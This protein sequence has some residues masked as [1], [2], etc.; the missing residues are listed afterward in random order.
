[1]LDMRISGDCMIA[2]RLV[3]K[4]CS[5]HQAGGHWV[6]DTC[7]IHGGERRVHTD[8]IMRIPDTSWIFLDPVGSLV[9]TLWVVGCGL[10]VVGGSHFFLNL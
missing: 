9:S 7:H 4:W 6:T 2:W 5:R 3:R 8:N 10:W 1:M